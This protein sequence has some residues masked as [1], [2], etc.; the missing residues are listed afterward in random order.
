PPRWTAGSATKICSSAAMT[1]LRARRRGARKARTRS[2][3]SRGE[4]HAPPLPA[5]GVCCALGGAHGR[6]QP[7]HGMALYGIA[8]GCRLAAPDPR[9]QPIFTP[10][11]ANDCAKERVFPPI[12]RA[13]PA[14]QGLEE[15]ERRE[16][17]GREGLLRRGFERALSW[18]S[19]DLGA[20]GGREPCNW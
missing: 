3:R 15:S 6:A 19:G 16:G 8:I 11:P 13:L 4:T 10:L 12:F 14:R 7:R 18:L 2:A 5:T 20:G 17:S 1:S 9:A